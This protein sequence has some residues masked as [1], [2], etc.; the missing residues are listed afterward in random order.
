MTIE[1]VKISLGEVS[2]TASQIRNLNNNLYVRLQDIKKEMNALSQ[3][4]NSDASN[5][6]RA[7]FNAFSARF[8]N[9][10]DVVESYAKFLDGT[11]T[12][13]DATEAAINNNASQFK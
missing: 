3:T 5:T 1:G 6:I 12:N 11:V 10:R 2:K 9:Y 13:Y 8:D 7:N 4:W